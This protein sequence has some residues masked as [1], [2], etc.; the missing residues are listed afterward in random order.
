MM[1]SR[2]LG[3][4]V[5]ASSAI[6]FASAASYH[7]LS[8]ATLTF[9]SGSGNFSWS[10]TPST[11]YDLDV[12]GNDAFASIG[13]GAYGSNPYTMIAEALGNTTD[14]TASSAGNAT[15]QFTVHNLGTSTISFQIDIT[16]SLSA[17]A[18]STGGYAESDASISN[19]GF[20]TDDF[21]LFNDDANSGSFSIFGSLRSHQTKAIT[22]TSSAEGYASAQAVPEPASMAI[23]GL[24]VLGMMRRRRST[25]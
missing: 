17:V 5:L 25:K 7:S 24:G 20:Q 23:L 4:I 12:S 18:D 19:T 6:G 15:H 1:R 10:D 3:V 16:F 14:G 11:S 13:Y 8:T 2:F 21:Q 22:F 9:S